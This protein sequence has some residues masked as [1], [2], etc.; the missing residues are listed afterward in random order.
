MVQKVRVIFLLKIIVEKFALFF[1]LACKCE[2]L[3]MLDCV[4]SYH[5]RS[6]YYKHHHFITNDYLTLNIIRPEPYIT[7]IRFPARYFILSGA[8][9]TI[10]YL[11]FIYQLLFMSYASSGRTTL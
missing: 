8:P 6:I 9:L 4:L 5:F 7:N 3:S 2:H 11:S 10:C 1:V